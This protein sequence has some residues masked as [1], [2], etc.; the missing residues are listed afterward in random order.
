VAR[1]L[2]SCHSVRELR[3]AG[4]QCAL[5]RA[6]KV[7]KRRHADGMGSHLRLAG[8]QVGDVSAGATIS[9]KKLCVSKGQLHLQQTNS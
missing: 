9:F 8:G 4:G 3:L 1:F 7:S 2:V 5:A 6:Q